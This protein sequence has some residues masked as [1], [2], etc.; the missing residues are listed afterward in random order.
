MHADATLGGWDGA[1]LTIDADPNGSWVEMESMSLWGYTIT[2]VRSWENAWWSRSG[3]GK[4]I[5]STIGDVSM[6]VFNGSDN[7]DTFYNETAIGTVA[8]GHGGDDNLIAHSSADAPVVGAQLYGG[9]GNDQLVGGN[10]KDWLFGG[11]GDDTMRGG[12]GADVLMG[13]SGDDYLSGGSDVDV[14]WI[15]GEYGYDTFVKAEFYPFGCLPVH[16]LDKTDMEPF[17]RWGGY[18]GDLSECRPYFPH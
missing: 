1:T 12:A 11:N 5:F 14:D 2:I 15:Y 9:D 7:P 17:E 4:I 8:Y 13:G 6:V 3:S 16:H 18:A 10:A